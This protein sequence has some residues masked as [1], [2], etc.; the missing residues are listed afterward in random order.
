MNQEHLC[1]EWVND[2]F[3]PSSFATPLSTFVPANL[4]ET[5]GIFQKE[6]LDR[7]KIPLN[8]EFQPGANFPSISQL[9]QVM[10]TE[11]KFATEL[12]HLSFLL[13]LLL[14]KQRWV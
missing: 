11:P 4:D 6:T 8:F 10:T 9:V 3:E 1:L 14:C 13:L 2:H 5:F 12:F 7:L